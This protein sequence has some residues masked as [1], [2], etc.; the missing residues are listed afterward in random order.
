M[1]DDRMATDSR[2]AIYGLD[3]RLRKVLNR[4][5]LSADTI[6]RCLPRTPLGGTESSETVAESLDRLVAA[7]IAER[8]EGVET[9]FRLVKVSHGTPSR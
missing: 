6:G 8:R 2:P 1:S 9:L 7:G 4:V 3:H 5:W